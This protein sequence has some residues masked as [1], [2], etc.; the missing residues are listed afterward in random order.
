MTIHDARNRTALA[1]SYCDINFGLDLLGKTDI[2]EWEENH[3]PN[4]FIPREK[5]RNSES[6][7]VQ[8]T[9]NQK[10]KSAKAASGTSIYISIGMEWYDMM[11]IYPKYTKISTYM[12]Q[13]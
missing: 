2:H 4:I 10:V 3:T 12:G 9:V 13:P 6:E 1:N 11:T 8:K 5:K 7:L